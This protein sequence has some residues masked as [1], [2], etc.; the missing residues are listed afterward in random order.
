MQWNRFYFHL[1]GYTGNRATKST[2]INASD[3]RIPQLKK[4]LY[5]AVKVFR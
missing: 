3:A 1:M 5:G 2:M 4:A